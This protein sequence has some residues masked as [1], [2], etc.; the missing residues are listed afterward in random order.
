M[1]QEI[2]GTTE[3]IA[4]QADARQEEMR[5]GTGRREDPALELPQDIALFQVFDHH[6]RF[7]FPGP[8]YRVTGGHGGEAILICG[9]RKT[10]LLDCG[11]AYCGRQTVSNLKRQ[12][13][14]LGREKLDYVLLSH[15]H[16]DHIGALPYILRAYPDAEVFG[17]SHCARI[18]R[19]H[20]AHAL[21]RELGEKARDLYVPGS[22][23][24]I[25]I[26]GLR[27]D[28][29]LLDGDSLFLGGGGCRTEAEQIVAYETGG[30]TQCSM[31]FL[32]KPLDLLF[33]SEST[34]IIESGVCSLSEG[35]GYI[36]TPILKTFNQALQSM[37]KCRDL[38]PSHLC[39]PHFGMV[40]DSF[41][42][43]YW[44]DFSVECENRVRFVRQLKEAG[45]S[46]EEMLEKYADRYWTKYKAMEQPKE[47]FMLNSKNILK[48]VLNEIERRDQDGI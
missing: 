19:R 34:G 11:M 29:V 48:A 40:P 46:D 22:T 10:A 7:G 32:V 41:I 36:H 15:S 33:A 26:D 8:I 9:S 5:Q 31:S 1:Q 3:T 44:E 43:Q 20:S 2:M 30:H 12:M 6:D 18:L 35:R 13:E 28:H 24:E 42:E 4:R 23:E 27:V 16:Y 39:L 47:A 38:H 37:K 25:P 21:M 45:L 14:A 17:S